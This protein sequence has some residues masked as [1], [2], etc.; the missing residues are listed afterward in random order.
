MTQEEAAVQERRAAQSRYAFEDVLRA[1][2][3]AIAGVGVIVMVV[4]AAI[5]TL[6]I[7]MRWL[8]GTGVVALNEITVMTFVVAISACLPAA[9][10]A[11]VGVI[12]D[13]AAGLVPTHVMTIM[14]SLG[15]L[16][17]LAFVALLAWSLFRFAG[18]MGAQGRTT[19][20]L[21]IPLAPFYYASSA[22]LGFAALV[23]TVVTWNDIRSASDAH[24]HE[25][26]ALLLSA[27]VIAAVIALLSVYA[28]FNL[29][30]ISSWVHSNLLSAGII[31]ILVMWFLILGM[32]P[33]A[34]ALGGVGIVGSIFF[35]GVHPTIG[36]FGTEVSGL[37][38]NYFIATLPL[39]LLMGSFAALAGVSNDLHRLSQ[40]LFGGFRGG[41]AMSTIGSC[42]GFG[43]V[44][45]SSLSTVAIFGRMSLPVMRKSGYSPELAVGC[46]AAG[47]TLGALV[48]P[49]TPLIIYALLSETSMGQLF[50]AAL[51]PAILALTLY[52]ATVA[53][54][55][56]IRPQ[57]APKP[58]W[59]P[60]S[61]LRAA[62]AGSASFGILFGIVMGGIFLGF[63]TAVEAAAVGAFGAFL[64][65]VMRGK[66]TLER[67]WA[68][69]GET[70]QTTA[71]IYTIMFGVM[72]FT[73][74]LAIT[75]LPETITSTISRIDLPPIYIVVMIVIALTVLCCILDSMSVLLITVPI[76][77]PLVS[78]LGYDLIW[79]GIVML[80]IVETG[81]ITPPLGLHIFLL[82]SMASD[83][84]LG[85]M[86][87]GVAPFVISDLLRLA[88]IVAFPALALW[89]PSIM[90]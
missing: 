77:V 5:T 52:L 53:I 18:N 7:L 26:R 27:A 31:S 74:F 41:L 14:R 58:A 36:A 46:V 90:R 57:L 16:L 45:G 23:Q 40:A 20:I 12:I 13:V 38:S 62:I 68:V 11:R 1:V 64:I 22:L 67:L 55:V 42:A 19:V 47:G 6:D 84:R 2:S 80:V 70:S 33:L 86:Y 34:A 87:K 73:F 49:S 44:S 60:I 51:I 17:L 4:T 79:W 83:V 21:A 59:Q 32:I 71:L 48:P 85:Q 3:N 75:G 30:T 61:E 8:I 63:F 28:A 37:L 50:A 88:L 39:F 56:R 69:L 81:M 65:A 29:G 54:A 78:A 72:I 10:A 15:A 9:L 82:R 76:L 43:A 35:I 66:L 25:R 89:L 24:R